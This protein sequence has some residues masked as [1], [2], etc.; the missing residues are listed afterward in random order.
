M[1]PPAAP[2]YGHGRR[3]LQYGQDA[4]KQH[5]AHHHAKRQWQGH[6]VK[7]PGSG[8]QGQVHHADAAP[9]KGH[10]IAR[11]VAAQPPA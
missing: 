3:I 8:K 7:E 10:G 1:N 5:Q 9:L 2:E 6:H 11:T 4:G